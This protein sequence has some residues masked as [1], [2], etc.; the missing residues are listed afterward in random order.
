MDQPTIRTLHTACVPPIYHKEMPRAL[1]TMSVNAIVSSPASPT[2]ASSPSTRPPKSPG[3]D[4]PALQGAEA[5]SAL[6]NAAAAKNERPHEASTG[7]PE[8]SVV[9]NSTST[10]RSR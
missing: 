1:F 7:P 10:A 5:S 9:R 4:T 8:A 2:S 6:H 3:G